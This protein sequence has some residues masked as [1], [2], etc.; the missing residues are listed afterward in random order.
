[1]AFPY[2][3]LPHSHKSMKKKSTTVPA[4]PA[5]T[6]AG[7]FSFFA[8]AAATSAAEALDAFEMRLAFFCCL[9]DDDRHNSDEIDDFLRRFS[10]TRSRQ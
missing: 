4:I 10:L 1:M 5:T 6:N 8:A 2:M 3:Y 7:W 9:N